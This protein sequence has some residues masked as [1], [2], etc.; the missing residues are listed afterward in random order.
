MRLVHAGILVSLATAAQAQGGRGPWFA[1]GLA[2]GEYVV[3]TDSTVA[4]G[5]RRSARI[6]GIPAMPMSFTA[7][8]EGIRADPYRGKKV[9]LTAWVKTRDVTGAGA[10]ITVG[11]AM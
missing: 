4:H 9:K 1:N 8:S 11:V 10:V 6:E 5:G 2:N 7:I 3:G